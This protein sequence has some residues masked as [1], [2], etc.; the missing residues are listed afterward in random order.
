MKE[1]QQ[2][3]YTTHT[4]I[5]LSLLISGKQGEKISAENCMSD[6]TNSHTGAKF[7]LLLVQEACILLEHTHQM[8]VTYNQSFYKWYCN[9]QQSILDT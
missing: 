8:Y 3:H 7:S 4:H 5:P 1:N 6:R 2:L 9:M